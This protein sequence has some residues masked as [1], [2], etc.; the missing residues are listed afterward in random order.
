MKTT[1]HTDRRKPSRYQSDAASNAKHRPD[2]KERVT[3]VAVVPGL[4]AA[5]KVDIREQRLFRS[6]DLDNDQRIPRHVLEQVLTGMGLRTEDARLA[7]SLAAARCKS[8]R[9]HPTP[10]P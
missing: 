5:A 3:K 8:I 2:T 4:A 1:A 7:E 10:I 6:L 9:K